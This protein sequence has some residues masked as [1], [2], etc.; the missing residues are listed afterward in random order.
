MIFRV[1]EWAD[2]I[3]QS[4][5]KSDVIDPPTKFESTMNYPILFNHTPGI[6]HESPDYGVYD[7]ISDPKKIQALKKHRAW[8]YHLDSTD[9]YGVADWKTDVVVVEVEPGMSY[10]DIARKRYKM[11]IDD[12]KER[13]E[14]AEHNLKAVGG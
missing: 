2:T 4:S 1:Q 8:H 6:L 11:I 9:D 3:E 10:N 13:L 14:I 5:Y 7:Y 12:L